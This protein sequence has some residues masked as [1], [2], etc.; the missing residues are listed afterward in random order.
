MASP[1]TGSET[2]AQ[3]RDQIDRVQ[4]RVLDAAEANGFRDPT[5]FAIRLALEEAISNAFRHGHKDIGDA[6]VKVEWTVSPGSIEMVIEDSGPGFDPDAIPDPTE[7]EHI[8]KPA[9]RGVHL[10]RS[11]MTDVTYEGKGNRVRMIYRA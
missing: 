2:I 11:F 5:L 4:Q 8:E 3:E 6:P 9:G 1:D 10:I 7:D